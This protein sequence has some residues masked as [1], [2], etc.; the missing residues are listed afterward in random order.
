M[1]TAMKMMRRTA[2]L[3]TALVLLAVLGASALGE[4]TGILKKGDSGEAVRRIQE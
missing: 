2:A 3:L 1:K 4:E